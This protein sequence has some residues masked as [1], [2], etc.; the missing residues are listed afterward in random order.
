MVVQTNKE[1]FNFL[2]H[3]CSKQPCR[4]KIYTKC[5]KM[6]ALY[7]LLISVILQRNKRDLYKYLS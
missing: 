1:N 6:I 5:N 4:P 7:G 3:N 2:K